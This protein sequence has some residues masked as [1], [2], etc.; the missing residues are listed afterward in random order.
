MLP[1]IF[2]DQNWFAVNKPTGLNSH[3]AHPGGNG[4]AEWFALHHELN[5]HI[6]SRLDKDT[7]G[8]LLFAKNKEASGL[9]QKIH[10]ANTAAKTYYFISDKKNK[11][12]SKNWRCDAPLDNKACFTKFSFIKTGTRYTLFS[13]T[14][15]RGRTHQIRRHAQMS[16][17]PIL[18]DSLYNGSPFPRLCLH[19]AKV[20]WPEFK[21]PIETLLPDSFDFLLRGKQKLLT[22]GAVALER[23]SNWL[24]SVTNSFRLIHRGEL[25]LPVS[26][27]I[28][29]SHLFVTSYDERTSSEQLR[30]KLKYLLSYLAEKQQVTNGVIRCHVKNP[31]QKK[32]IHDIL[33]WGE[34]SPSITAREH[35]LQYGIILDSSQHTGLFLD[36]R[37][38]R[39]R[40]QQTAQGKRVANLFSFTCSFS[41]AAVKGGAEVVF[42]VDL[43]GSAL[44]RGKENFAANGLDKTGSGKFIKEDVLKWLKRQNRKKEKEGE[45]FPHWDLLICDPPVF[46]AG[47]KQGFHVEKMWTQLAE[48]IKNI[49]SPDGKALFANNHRGGKSSIYKNT[50]QKHFSTVIPLSPPFDFPQITGEP[51]HVRIYWCEK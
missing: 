15:S 20:V 14:I 42:S 49:L 16:G 1:S 48:Q 32:L 25:S 4:A 26:I 19:C 21:K 31:H 37:D 29:D 22:E 7:S 30:H 2:E 51:E 5:L 34:K 12:N 41:A 18:G 24:P 9:A 44:A 3:A 28:Y 50:L 47:T 27:D 40:I 6:C 13:A 43:A 36:Q 8:I 17:V 45:T 35:G 39:R 33:H 10:E 38:S 46:A 11:S 23:R